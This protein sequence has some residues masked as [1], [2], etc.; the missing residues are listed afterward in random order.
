MKIKD[1][2]VVRLMVWALHDQAVA[3]GIGTAAECKD[4]GLVGR[5]RF[6][7]VTP[8]RFKARALARFIVPS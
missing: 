5:R 8:A 7:E 6:S 1:V 3:G 2:R 4:A